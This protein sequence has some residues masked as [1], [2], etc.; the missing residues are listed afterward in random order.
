MKSDAIDLDVWQPVTGRTGT[1]KSGSSVGLPAYQ[2]YKAKRPMYH[3]VSILRIRAPSLIRA[4]TSH[5]M[6]VLWMYLDAKCNV[7]TYLAK[8][9]IFRF[10][11]LCIAIRAVSWNDH[12][13]TSSTSV[14]SVIHSSVATKDQ[15][16]NKQSSQ[17]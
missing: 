13:N 12:Y 14:M 8:D 1:D 9:M 5:R 4:D 3:G 7:Y 16:A 6:L 15:L 10:L 2:K 11:S 17:N